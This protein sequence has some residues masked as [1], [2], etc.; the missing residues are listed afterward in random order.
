MSGERFPPLSPE[1]MNAEQRRV[2]DRIT[3]GPRGG[4]RGPFK[5]LL[6]SPELADRAQ[7]LGEYVRF[8]NT[9]PA[10]LNELAIL[11]VGRHWTAQYEFYAHAR[12]AADAGLD[13]EVTAAIADGRR[14]ERMAQDE[15]EIYDFCTELLASGGV[16]D[17]AFQS[18]YKRF[19]GAGVIDLIGTMGYYGLVS[20][21]LNVDRYG[22]PE[23]A[24][25]PLAPLAA[26]HPTAPRRRTE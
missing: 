9:I 20:L 2:A 26:D 12:L 8:E 25:A 21:V 10:R 15:T 18:V 17:A 22:L 13:P 5:A 16:S 24:S 1:T 6:S 7:R 14:P 3:A 19:G 23:G 4:L 11:L